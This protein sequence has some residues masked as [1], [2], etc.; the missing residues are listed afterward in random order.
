[1]R[2]IEDK[3]D[4]DVFDLIDRVQQ[5]DWLNLRDVPELVSQA[6]PCLDDKTL[7]RIKSRTWREL[8]VQPVSQRRTGR[9]HNKWA[10]S[11]AILLVLLT[12]AIGMSEEVRAELKRVLQF[13]PG[14]GAVS[15]EAEHP[16][17]VLE[18]PVVQEVNG[19]TWK[20]EGI[21]LQEKEAWIKLSGTGGTPP[22]KVTLTTD[23]PQKEQYDFQRGTSTS[24]TKG[25]KAWYDYQG[26]IP[27]S[28]KEA[29]HLH[30]PSAVIGPLPLALAK[31]ADDLHGL[32]PTA[33]ANGVTITAVVTPMEQ[34]R[35]WV[36]LLSLLPDE[37][38][39]D[40]YGV[41]PI[42]KDIKLSLTD[43]KGHAIQIETEEPFVNEKEFYFTRPASA[44]DD[45]LLSISH[46]RVVNRHAPFEK[47]SLPLPEQGAVEIDRTVALDGLP[48]HFFKVERISPESVRVYMNT[49]FD[50]TQPKTLQSFRVDMLDPERMSY[51]W[52][53]NEETEAIEFIELE[54]RPEMKK[55]TFS[56]GE[57]M[58]LIKGPWQINLE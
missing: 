11:A 58:F 35:L 16:L 14:F 8:G 19:T 43:E 49:H 53:V 27:L 26:N 25:W 23:P 24:S 36:N 32:G 56:I 12:A 38:Q 45:Y 44:A 33:E 51:M 41:Y 10:V 17:Y 21:L 48:V 37:L 42:N 52:K 55:L 1:M 46:I 57:P 30:L 39:A 34:D 13:L 18:K 4:K 20:V 40:S 9:R 29:V 28:E 2:H 3:D 54:V 15:E 5:E 22:D 31:Q 47:V 6:S 7:D 50:S